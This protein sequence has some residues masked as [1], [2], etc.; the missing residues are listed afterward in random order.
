[1][2]Q[3]FKG[4]KADG[5][6][7]RLLRRQLV[8]VKKKRGD[9]PPRACLSWLALA[10]EPVHRDPDSPLLLLSSHTI[11]DWFSVMTAA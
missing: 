1:M 6:W 7:W 4:M 8:P 3:K 5:G 9:D 11:D 2:L 10:W